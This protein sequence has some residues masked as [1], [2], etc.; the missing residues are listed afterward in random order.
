[1]CDKL[2]VST[3]HLLFSELQHVFSSDVVSVGN[4]VG[5]Y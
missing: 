3:N 5:R 1:M 2:I 4:R